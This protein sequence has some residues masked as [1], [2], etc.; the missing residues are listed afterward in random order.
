MGRRRSELGARLLIVAPAAVLGL[1]STAGVATAE[2]TTET[3]EGPGPTTAVSVGR[4]GQAITTAGNGTRFTNIYSGQYGTLGYSLLIWSDGGTVIVDLPDSSSTVSFVSGAKNGNSQAVVHYTDGTTAAWTILDDC[5]VGCTR[6]QTFTG[7]RTIDKFILT[8][9]WD[10]WLLDFLTFDTTP[11]TTT[12]TTVAETTTTTT[13]T[14]PET[15]TTEESTTTIEQTTTT[16]TTTSTTTTTIPAQAEEARRTEEARQTYETEDRCAKANHAFDDCP[17]FPG[18]TTTSSTTTT[19]TPPETTI[20]PTTIPPTTTPPQTSTT[21][22]KT[23]PVTT[24]PDTTLPEPTTSLQ[25]VQTTTPAPDTTPP[26]PP[27]PEPIPTPL[28]PSQPPTPPPAVAQAVEILANPTALQEATQEELEAIFS[29]ID[30]ATLTPQ[31]GEALVAEL[32]KAPKKAKKAFQE[33][34]NVFAGVFDS[35]KMADQEI[36]VGDRRTLIA[37]ANTLA[38]TATVLARRR[39]H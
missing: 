6:T 26:P 33:S 17:L 38:A 14:V 19:S 16:T 36:T 37:V 1:F 5:S 39:E 35:F 22:P 3:F 12:T 2:S 18:R 15:T 30:P 31:Q 28:E 7:D 21:P 4:N 34:V 25:T 20:P 9:D 23:V 29:E 10:L 32:N 11:P 8:L 27:A 13:T 24:V